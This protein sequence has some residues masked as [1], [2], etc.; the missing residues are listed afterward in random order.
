MVRVG[1]VGLGFMG[2]M[3]FRCWNADP[4]AKIVAVCDVDNDK[5]SGQFAQAGNIEGAQDN[6]DL[7]NIATFTNLDNML[8][9]AQLDAV[10]IA[11]PTYLHAQA[12]IKA[13]Q[14]GVHV[15][16][17]K[18][19]ALDSAE[20]QTMIDAAEKTGKTL[21]VGHCIRFWPEYAYLKQLIQSGQ[22]GNLR[23]ATFTRISATPTWSWQNWILDPKKAGGAAHDLHIHDADFVQY[24]CGLPNAVF[25]QA[26]PGFDNG[27]DHVVAQYIYNNGPVITAEGGWL[28]ADP[29]GFKMAYNA[30][31]EKA[32]I[33]FDSTQSPTIK[34][35]PA[36]GQTFTPE[37]PQKDGYALEIHHFIQSITGQKVPDILT[38]QQ[39]LQS[40]KLI[41]AEIK[42]AQNATPVKLT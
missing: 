28:C 34:V 7:S 4:N 10:S 12:T 15:F 37:M 19:M 5:L 32:T 8:K 21:Q 18:P 2:R 9:E 3:H 24:L 42:S 31:L 11:L 40:V 16:C 6:L 26:V 39:S 1:I 35:H 13:L 38:P 27:A 29:F 41:E 22:Y 17:E 23:F 25:C 20:C 36:A 33:S 30:V 14:A